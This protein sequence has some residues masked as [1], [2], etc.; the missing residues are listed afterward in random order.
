[1]CLEKLD[2]LMAKEKERIKNEKTQKNIKYPK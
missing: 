2:I 1:M